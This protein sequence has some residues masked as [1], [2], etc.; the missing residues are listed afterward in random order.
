[1][2]LNIN[3]EMTIYAAAQFILDE[4]KSPLSSL[5]L[6]D[7]MRVRDLVD[8]RVSSHRSLVLTA[9]KR[10]SCQPSNAKV[11]IETAD[12][13]FELIQPCRV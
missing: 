11:F 8:F 2:F 1:M 9:L 13:R 10:R 5:E 12:G 4:I 6:A 7:Q 3:S